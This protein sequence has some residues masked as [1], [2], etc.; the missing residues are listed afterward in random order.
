MSADSRPLPPAAVIAQFSVADFDA[1]KETFD[2]VEQVRR[3]AGI[4]GHHINRAE[5]D[6]NQLGIYMAVNDIDKARAFTESDQLKQIMRDAGVTSPPT[7]MWMTPVREDIVWDRELPAMIITHGVADFDSWLE[8][9][10]RAGELQ[11]SKGIV[12][13]AANRSTDDPSVAIVY[14]QAESFD[15][16]REFLADADLAVAMKEAGVTSEPE[17]SFHVGGWAKIY[18]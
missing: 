11:R 3:D 4:G 6:P 14:H 2:S 15:D 5:D 13:Q 16:L 7:F 8:G 9:Y 12:G 17:V 10:D 18:E 1:W